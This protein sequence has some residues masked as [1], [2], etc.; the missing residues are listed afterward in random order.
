MTTQ[1]TT[2]TYSHRRKWR[3][4][5]WLLSLFSVSLIVVFGVL[6]AKSEY[7][8]LGAE[9]YMYGYP[10]V[11][12]DITRANGSQNIGPVN[13]LRRVRQFPSPQFRDVVRPNVDTL[14]TNAF[15]DMDQ[16]PWVFT[17]PPNSQRYELMAFLDAWTDVFAAPG[18]RTTGTQGGEFLLV[19][20]HW[21]GVTPESL[22]LLRSPTRMVWLIGRTQTHGP[23]DYQLVHQLQDGLHFQSLTDWLAGSERETPP[24]Q[25]ALERPV[26][27]L[28]QMRTMKTEI[29]FTRLAKLMTDNPPKAADAPLVLK[30]LRIGV[31][32]GAPPQ[33]GWL[34]R[35]CV[36]LGRRIADWKVAQELSR[37]HGQVGAWIT[38]PA[39]LGNY[40]THYNIRAV[41][42]MIGLGANLPIDATYPNTRVDA[43]DRALHGDHSYQLHFA[44]DRLPPVSAFWSV[45]AYGEDDYLIENSEQR[46]ARASHDD[47]HYNPDGSLDLWVQ[48][49]APVCKDQRNWL[50]VKAG[51]GFS[52][53]AR[54]YG[55]QAQALD[56][57]WQMPAIERVD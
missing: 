26:A 28:E 27:P 3:L 49:Q 42:S 35:L 43:Q 48:A 29:F 46:Y 14:Y 45:T 52:L 55:P 57:R 10:L 11:I 47:L 38:P 40:G 50:P 56:G 34:D 16:G 18:T 6:V 51:K 39:M 20:P 31:A 44:A 12:M 9:G 15:I 41:V 4:T 32:P 25:A 24:W 23:S 7:I 37:S 22:T 19:G 17:L 5:R 1:L 2:T 21:Q 53:N 54:L 30:L 8:V 33:W 13:Q 36:A